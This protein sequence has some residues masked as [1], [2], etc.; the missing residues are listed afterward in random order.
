MANPEHIKWLLE[1][2]DSWNQR[3]Q[4]E[5]FNPDLSSAD[6]YWEFRY[7]KKLAT[8]RSI[9][10][11]Y[12][13]FNGAN[14]SGAYLGSQSAT[15][16]ANLD[17]ATFLFANLQRANLNNARLENAEFSGAVLDGA[18]LHDAN[19]CGAEMRFTKCDKT[20]FYHADLTNTIFDYADLENA[21]FIRT[22]L[23]EAD[24]SLAKMAGVNLGWS[25]LW[26]ANLF[27]NSGTESRPFNSENHGK[28][29]NCVADLIK[30]CTEHKTNG[31]DDVLYFRG[32]HNK[33][34]ELHPS[35]M[36]R[37]KKSGSYPLLPKESDM[38]LELMSQ[39]PEDFNNV[40]SAL[41]QW[42]LAQHHGLKTRLLDVTRNP[43]VALFS[44]CETQKKHGRLH[45]FSVPKKLIKPFNSDTISIIA[46]FCKLT[47][48]EQIS[49]LGLEAK[50]DEELTQ[51]LT[52][53]YGPNRAIDRLYYLIQQE[54]P[55][56]RK[57]I[58]PRDFFR[59]F[60]VEPQQSFARIRTQSGAF[61]IS[62]FHERFEEIEILKKNSGIPIYSHFTIEVPKES[63]Q[64]ILNELQ[65]LNVTRETLFPGLD[66]SAAAI[67][68]NYSS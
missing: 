63:K 53:S 67:T 64:D 66:E 31:A 40:P 34:W 61:L 56:F 45:V 4:R 54:K 51:N 17:H 52:P 60:V 1:G 33:K 35:V 38:L 26:E 39:R 16:G 18:T 30:E 19:L 46:N 22:T 14:L 48:P 65:M 50:G 62:A 7:A 21:L 29:I 3:R 58:D 44:A 32:E 20:E 5:D 36:R 10:L 12:I 6:I 55:N 43:L 59:I 2:A 24:L 37:L 49:L 68:K 27:R 11:S 8:D 57:L 28:R 15:T 41:A 47:R 23:V 25:R 13:N 9:P 42:V